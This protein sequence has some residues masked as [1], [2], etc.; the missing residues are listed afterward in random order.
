VTAR[1]TLSYVH[2]AGADSQGLKEDRDRILP[3]ITTRPIRGAVCAF[4]HQQIPLYDFMSSCLIRQTELLITPANCINSPLATTHH[5]S[6]QQ[7][8]SPLG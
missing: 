4:D 8:G 2:K 1:V 5:A 3:L 6:V 7:S